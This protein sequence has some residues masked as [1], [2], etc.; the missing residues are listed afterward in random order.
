MKKG[1]RWIVGLFLI[2]L[3]FLLLT[4]SVYAQVP[5]RP[6]ESTVLDETH[7]LSSDTIQAID[8]ENRAW[9]STTEQLQVGV[10][11]TDSLSGDIESL[12]NEVFRKWQVG[13]SGTNNGI[14]LVIAL[15]DRK[16][17]IE[18]S[19]N[20]ATV[21]TDVEARRI[22]EDARSFFREGDYN[23]GV[24]YIVDA[25]GD[26][27]YGTD[28][29]Q[30]RMN[31]FEEEHGDDE[32]IFALL[33]FLIVVIVM[34]IILKGGGRGGRGGRGGGG[35][36]LLWMLLNGTSGSS[37]SRSHSSGSS[38]FGGGGWSGGGGGGGGASSGW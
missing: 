30:A 4:P 21:L 1:V 17:R 3:M 16:F 28:R 22:L 34:V 10:Y 35:D 27:F 14:L 23:G 8:S 19:D 2:P 32:S 5:D 29:A 26:A 24:H 37:N 25:I 7:S 13:F 20:A 15:E 31:E 6:L 9:K 11:M 38:G 18:T 33:P 36:L 12:A